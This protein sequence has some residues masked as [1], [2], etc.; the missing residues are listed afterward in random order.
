MVMYWIDVDTTGVGLGDEVLFSSPSDAGEG[1]GVDEVDSGWVS[2]EV[3]LAGD[4]VAGPSLGVWDE[5]DGVLLVWGG[6]SVDWA[7]GAEV[8]VGV[9]VEG[10][11]GVW[12][13]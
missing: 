7:G 12:L 3:G 1:R 5:A 6:R 13:V 10:D 4:D 8:A 11:E 2:A 9:S